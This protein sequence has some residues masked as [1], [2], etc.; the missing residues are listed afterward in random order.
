MHS[1]QIQLSAKKP[2]NP[3][4][5]AELKT[6][7]DHLRKVRLDH[8]LSQADVARILYAS[9]T[10]VM[11]WELNRN[12][13]TAKFA[14]RIIEFLGYVP[15]QNHESLAKRLYL[16][17][18]IS[19]KTQEQ[20][21]NEPGVDESN[22]RLIELGARTPFLKTREKIERFVE[23]ALQPLF[24]ILSY[25]PARFSQKRHRLDIRH[26]SGRLGFWVLYL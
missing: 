9:G 15:F 24:L 3:A 8:G 11:A 2:P 22:L 26:S 5:P 16:A 23:N 18:L 6:L 4:Y 10:M 25:N 12:Q 17:R 13:P 1:C 20:V 21:S 7:G 14:K 19:G